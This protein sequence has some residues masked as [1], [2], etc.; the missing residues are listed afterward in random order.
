[1]GGGH[2]T[3]HFGSKEDVL[4]GMAPEI[5]SRFQQ[6][7]AAAPSSD[8]WLVARSAGV[9]LLAQFFND[10][11]ADIRIDVLRLWHSEPA[12]HRRY[13]SFMSTWE[14]MLRQFCA[15]GMP[16]SVSNQ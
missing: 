13:L 14:D 6:D 8:K 12:L 16:T 7:L 11:D 4:F 15:D 9:S 1:M 10:M 5:T 2:A 3:A